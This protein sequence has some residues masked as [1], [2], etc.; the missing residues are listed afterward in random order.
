MNIKELDKKYILP[1]YGRGDVEFVSG[2][3]ATLTDSD[4]KNYIDFTSGIGVVSVGHANKRVNS[5]LADQLSKITD[6]SN[7]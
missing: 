7:L 3:N 1:T 5:A 2:D 6:T 4:G